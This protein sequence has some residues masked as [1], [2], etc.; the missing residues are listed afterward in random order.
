[1]EKQSYSSS[2]TEEK[3]DFIQ[4]FWRKKPNNET[5]FNSQ[6]TFSSKNGGKNRD[7]FLE[8]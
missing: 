6:K 7:S 8:N 1:M 4:L 2:S 3:Q 5:N